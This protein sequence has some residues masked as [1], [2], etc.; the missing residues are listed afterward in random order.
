MRIVSATVIVPPSTPIDVI[1]SPS[2]DSFPLASLLDATSAVSIAVGHDADSIPPG[3]MRIVSAYVFVPPSTPID[4]IVSPSI[5]SFPLASLL[6]ATSAVSIAVGHDADSIPPGI[7]RIV[8]A[9][10]I[11]PPSTPIDVIVSPSID[12]FPL[13]SLLDA[14]SAVSIAVGHDADSIPPGIMRIVSADVLVLVLR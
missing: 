7:M 13:A 8:S 12:S 11:V 14:T 2:I 3:I 6:D 4:V 1:V 9:D 5:D 10:V